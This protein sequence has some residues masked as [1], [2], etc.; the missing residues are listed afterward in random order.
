MND[1]GLRLA[2]S[3]N[4]IEPMGMPEPSGDKVDLTKLFAAIRRQRRTIMIGAAIGLI[5]GIAHLATTPPTYF[6]ATSV[7]LDANVNR[8]VG[9]IAAMEDSGTDSAMEG[10]LHILRSQQLALKV[11]DRLDLHNNQ[12]F[13]NPPSSLFSQMIGTV[14][15]T[16]RYP[17]VLLRS[18]TSPTPEGATPAVAP[19]PEQ[20]D[21]YMRE[22][23][24]MLLRGGL[25]VGRQGESSV[26][27][28]GYMVHDPQLA[29]A[30]ANA[31][32]EAYAAD[33][34]TANFE[35]TQRTTEWMRARLT[36]L[37]TSSMSAG[38]AAETFRLENGLVSSPSGV[39]MSQQNASQLNLDLAT[40][41]ADAARSR[42]LLETYET[43]LAGGPEALAR[44]G[45]EGGYSGP[46]AGTGDTR[47]IE[48]QEQ[49]AALNA[50]LRQIEQEFGPDHAQAKAVRAQIALQAET[51]YAEIGR[52][53]DDARG[54]LDVAEARV[55]ALRES[56]GVA[57]NATNAEG[58]AYV[59]FRALEQRALTLDALYQN[60]LAKFE[61]IEQQK[62]F[63]ISNVRV[64]SA[65]AVPLAAAGPRTTSTLALMLV[66]GAIFGSVVAM[67]REYRDWYFRTGDNVEEETG[68]K[69]LGYL[70]FVVVEDDKP[71][72][73]GR[74]KAARAMP[75]PE[76]G[77]LPQ[78][79]QPFY[80][81]QNPRSHFT[82]TL[83]NVRFS[84]GMVL[85]GKQCRIIGVTSVLPGE[86][87]ST[88]ASN[89][90]GLTSSSGVSTL[91]IDCDQ[92]NPGLSRSLRHIRGNGLVEAITGKK[93]W[94]DVLRASGD[95]GLHILPCVT[96]PFMTHVADLLGSPQMRVIL[97]EASQ[98]YSHIIL[99]LPPLGPVVDARMLL[100]YVDQVLMVVEWGK[101][102]RSLVR[103]T[104][105][106][107]H[108]LSDRL[109]G[110]VLNKTDMDK[111]KDYSAATDAESHYGQYGGYIA[112]E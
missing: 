69:F 12:T 78:I 29:A 100:P 24:A 92:R 94:R 41:T 39:L 55:A 3:R 60:F 19:T 66:I 42:A 30:I 99:D 48:S 85:S 51:L 64:L 26:L 87:K 76:T 32:A 28:V 33:V 79:R 109:L 103:K 61:E 80:A 106:R 11:V 5:L 54:A 23:S 105:E 75:L 98:H 40:A 73:T 31:Y 22:Q 8:A 17:I 63:P 71:S 112:Q 67:W 89:L 44:S 77:A 88:I 43:A 74:R 53:R 4:T 37:E 90:A 104:I 15:G 93:N 10:V 111:L 46:S 58:S 59:Q 95:T 107:D 102:P 83:Q 35:A 47:L 110:I 34:L 82:E 62:N 9:E 91:L 7:M 45:Q 84:A 97:E 81:V 13:L 16:L 68:Q 56:L 50:R 1:L 108:I 86:G 14:I 36:E 27:S 6:A 101:T 65:A 72:G 57:V 96:P 2:D 38:M 70:P 52:E 20:I 49:L 25:L 18:A 21:A